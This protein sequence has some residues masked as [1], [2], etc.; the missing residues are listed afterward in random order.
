MACPV[1]TSPYETKSLTLA[2]AD[3]APL[4]DVS[5]GPSQESA[6]SIGYVVYT[7]ESC[8]FAC[9]AIEPCPSNSVPIITRDCYTCAPLTESGDIASTSCEYDSTYV[10]S[11]GT[12]SPTPVDDGEDEDTAPPED[13]EVPGNDDQAPSCRTSWRYV[14]EGDFDGNGSQDREF[15]D[16]LDEPQ[17]IGEL[18][19]S[20]FLEGWL[21]RDIP[22]EPDCTD[23]DIYE[24]EY[25]CA[26]TASLL[27]ETS[28]SMSIE[29]EVGG[30]TY[31]RSQE[32]I[33]VTPGPFRVTATCTT[34]WGGYDVEV[35][36]GD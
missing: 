4:V 5:D 23:V 36:F 31:S 7:E 3:G 12:T 27:I 32:A 17:A 9:V 33:E 24:G 21:D 22:A 19:S 28:R 6:G 35:R 20:L 29:V 10:E 13:D 1:G 8:S 26:G 25:T 15:D 2:S 11:T 16:Q 30:T 18:D 14:F 34:D